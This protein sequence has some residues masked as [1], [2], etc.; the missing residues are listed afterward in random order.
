MNNGEMF[1]GVPELRI[2]GNRTEDSSYMVKVAP[3][4]DNYMD[5]QLPALLTAMQYLCQTEGPFYRGI[6]GAGLAYDFYMDSRCNE[7]L[8]YFNL[9]RCTDIVAAFGAASEIVKKHLNIEEWSEEFFS[10]A[11]SSLIFEYIEGEK[12]PLALSSTS[13]CSYYRE[14]PEGFTRQ[15]S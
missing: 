5:P 14:V 12:T 13:L 8:I 4:P 6:R 3:G 9:Y 11:K 1:R 10:S 2:I 15:V 7:G